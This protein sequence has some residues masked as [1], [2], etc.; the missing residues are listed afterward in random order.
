MI[1]DNERLEKEQIQLKERLDLLEEKDRE[2][3][4]MTYP[5]K[6]NITEVKEK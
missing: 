5:K 6:Q 3:I 2:F 1:N 4:K